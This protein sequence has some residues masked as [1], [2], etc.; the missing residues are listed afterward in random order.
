MLSRN[1]IHITDRI[2]KELRRDYRT[3]F[4]YTAAP[5]LVMVLTSGIL[6]NH[7]VTFNRVGLIILGLF[8]TAPAFLFAAFALHRDK[9]RGTLDS[10]FT[11]PV[12][13]MDILVA[14]VV[15]FSIPSVIQMG[16]TLS[17]TYAFLDL[18]AAAAWWV[19]G[20]LAMLASV[21][22]VVLGVLATFLARNELQLT[23]VLVASG[24][25]H[26]MFSGLFRPFE[27]MN[28]WMQAISSLAP[29]RYAVGAVTEFQ[30]SATPTTTAWVCIGVTV[31][32]IVLASWLSSFTALQ[33]KSA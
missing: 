7:P 10:L 15:A 27:E 25:L 23:R 29:W 1:A 16:I 4:L 30:T 18:Q 12:R 17:V 20:L 6:S 32:I 9:R 21:L 26:L 24:P 2:L 33:R 22:G 31:G 8:P 11:Y 3:V 13:R 28:G 14:Y 5:A 19:I